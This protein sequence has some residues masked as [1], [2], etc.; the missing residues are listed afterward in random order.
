MAASAVPLARVVVLGAPG[1]VAPDVLARGLVCFAPGLPGYALVALMSRA[2]YAQGNARTPAAAAAGGWAVAIA[3]DIVLATAMPRDWTVA[4]IGLG[5]S[6]GV[7]VSG[8]WLVVATARAAGPDALAGL[9]RAAAAAVTAGVAG[10]LA[11]GLVARLGHSREVLPNL[12]AAVGVGLLAGGIH[13]A[14]AGL[15]DR[16]TVGLLLDRRRLRRA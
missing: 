12:A 14:A 7:T 15:V 6:V 4:A 13:L 11:G 9:R 2:L 1:H 8:I 10:A 16:P 3:A 5:T